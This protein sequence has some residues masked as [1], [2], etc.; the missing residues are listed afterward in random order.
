[1]STLQQILCVEDEDDIR[2]V[3]TLSLEAI[4]GFTVDACAS[5]PEAIRRAPDVAPDL[6]LLDVM[7]PG[8]DG[9]TTLGELRKSP[10]L[11]RTPVMFL[12]AKVQSS[13]VQHYLSLGAIGVLSKPFD[14]MTLPGRIREAWEQHH[15]S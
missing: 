12:T 9:P 3:L 4:G 8:M 2:S 13:E 15:G 10:A 14:P 1:M 7:M 5:G 11:R 6:I